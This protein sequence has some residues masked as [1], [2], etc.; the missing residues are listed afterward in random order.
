M[1][2]RSTPSP[3]PEGVNGTAAAMRGFLDA[4]ARFAMPFVL[5]GA[6]GLTTKVVDYESRLSHIESNRFTDKD[7]ISAQDRINKEF[8]AIHGLIAELKATIA[9]LTEK[10]REIPPK[11]FKEKVDGIE[12]GLQT[13]TRKVDELSAEVRT[14]IQLH[15]RTDGRP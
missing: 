15:E 5:L 11:L 4:V 9:T 6:G 3:Q 8:L 12:V 2:K 7:W 13:V 14:F 10:V 1:V